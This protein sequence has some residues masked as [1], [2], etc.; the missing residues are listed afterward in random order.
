M[1]LVFVDESGD[2]GLRDVAGS[3]RYFV[4]TLVLIETQETADEVSRRIDALRQ[5][6]HLSPRYEFHFF[7][8]KD[9]LRRAFLTA[10]RHGQ[11]TYC[12][13]VVDKRKLSGPEFERGDMFYRSVCAT[14]FQEARPWLREASVQFDESGSRDFRRNLASHL[15]RVI[16]RKE[17]DFPRLKKVK[18]QDSKGNNLMQLADMICGAVAR[19]YQEEAGAEKKDKEEFRRL[20]Q[21]REQWVRLWPG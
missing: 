19:A 21:G 1:M 16:N 5:E 11:F 8:T 4:L 12:A 10:A 13:L 18:A 17:D 6:L 14:A 2:T 7:K 3:T 20:V 9:V 15:M